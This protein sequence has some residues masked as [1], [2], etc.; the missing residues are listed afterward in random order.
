MTELRTEMT[1]DFEHCY[2]AQ[3][4]FYINFCEVSVQIFT[5]VHFGGMER[6]RLFAFSLLICKNSLLT[7]DTSS[8][9]DMCLPIIFTPLVACVF[10]FLLVYLEK[11]NFKILM[12]HNKSIFFYGTNLGPS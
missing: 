10:I 1:S 12:N 11:Q 9:Y 8:S 3:G 2:C 7:L 6:E 4:H 5:H